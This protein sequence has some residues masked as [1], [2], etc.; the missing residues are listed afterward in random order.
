[1]PKLLLALALSLAVAPA[2][3][4][5]VPLIKATPSG[6]YSVVKADIPEAAGAL[7]WVCFGSTEKPHITCFYLLDDGSAVTVEMEPVGKES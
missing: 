4:K 7:P 6:R 3:A 5:T 2:V 1:M